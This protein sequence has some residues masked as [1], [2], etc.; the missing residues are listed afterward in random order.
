QL[1][2]VTSYSLLSITVRF[3]C[4]VKQAKAL[5]YQTLAINDFNVLHGAVEFNEACQEAGNQQII[6]LRLAYTPAE[7]VGHSAVLLFA[8]NIK[9]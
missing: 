1:L 3:S 5:R 7:K 6:V 9:G 4:N 8:K 2:S